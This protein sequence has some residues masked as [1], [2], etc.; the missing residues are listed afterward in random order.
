MDPVL[1]TTTT[2]V[3]HPPLNLQSTIHHPPVNPIPATRRPRPP[4]RVTARTLRPRRLRSVGPFPAPPPGRR[5][6]GP[7][8]P[9]PAPA[10]ALCPPCS[11]TPHDSPTTHAH[12]YIYPAFQKL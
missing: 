4:H 9:T 2:K 6:K 3:D 12:P 1:D 5:F 10:F 11:D 7:L 8:G